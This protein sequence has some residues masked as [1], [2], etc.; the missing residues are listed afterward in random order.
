M[1]GTAVDGHTFIAKAVALGASA[2]VCEKMPTELKA[3][4]TYVKVANSSVSLGF[5]ATNFYD[6]PSSKLKLVAVTGTNGK[7]ST[8]TMCYELFRTLGY[9][10]GLLS[11]VRNLVDNVEVP[12]TH[13]TRTP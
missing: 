11:T 4:V 1:R 3:G 8:V 12:A 9:K 2:I 5:A 7:T 10:V 6:N 13:T